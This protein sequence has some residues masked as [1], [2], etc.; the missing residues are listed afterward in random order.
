MPSRQTLKLI[1]Q[2]IWLG[3]NVSH[4]YSDLK[5]IGKVVNT[6]AS[7]AILAREYELAL[8]WLEEGRS[9]V[10][11]QTLQ[12]HSPLKALYMNYPDLAER[13]DQVTHA[14]ENA[15]LADTMKP[16]NFDN[17]QVNK[18]IEQQAQNHHRLATDY[19]K[20]IEEVQQLQGFENLF[21][22]KK[23]VDLIPAA[24]DGPVVTINVYTHCDAL[25][26]CPSGSVI[27]ISLP[28]FTHEKA[29]KMHSELLECLED[30]NVRK[31]KL[32]KAFQKSTGSMLSRIKNILSS[33]WTDV[34]HPILLALKDVVSTLCIEIGQL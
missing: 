16:L 23:L 18:S 13:L 9:I 6:A 34:V 15:G 28:N 8:E 26:L 30:A 2:C 20:L 33:L 32:G 22:P 11:Q 31:L 27:H 25:A 29:N 19:E 5:N 21:K 10:W 24:Q 12:L 3:Q 14:L 7:A 1:P 17:I 4:R